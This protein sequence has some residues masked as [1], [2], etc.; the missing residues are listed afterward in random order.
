VASEKD[1]RG[2]EIGAQTKL[3]AQHDG[4]GIVRRVKIGAQNHARGAEDVRVF[5][6]E[7]A[8][9]LDGTLR[10]GDYVLLRSGS[11]QK[12]GGKSARSVMSVTNGRPG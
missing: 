10:A 11:I 7:R 2:G 6:A 8:S 12:R 4:V 5:V 3:F 1:D 9:L